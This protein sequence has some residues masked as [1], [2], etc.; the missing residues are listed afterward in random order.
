MY[1]H[2][3]HMTRTNAFKMLL[4]TLLMVVGS[5]FSAHAQLTL[6]TTFVNNARPIIF[7]VGRT[8]ISEADQ[9]WLSDTLRA[10]LEALGDDGI[11]VVRAA[12]SPEGAYKNNLSLA[13]RRCNAAMSVLRQF[14]YDTSELHREIVAE[15]YE[16]LRM[17]M[18]MAG[19]PDYPMLDS[20]VQKYSSTPIVL[21]SK[22]QHVQGGRFWKRVL[23][24]YYPDLRAVRI[25]AVRKELVF[26][27]QFM[28]D[29]QSL[30]IETAQEDTA[31]F[32]PMPKGD[33]P[34]LQ[35]PFQ[36]T[37]RTHRIPLLNV[38][39]N[40]L[41]DAFYMPNYGFAPMWNI[42]VEYYPR[43]G[44]MTYGAWFMGPYWHNWNQNKFFQIRNYELEARY[45]F[46]GTDRAY[47]RGLFVGLAV[48]A[49]KYGIGLN[50]RKG[51][52][53]EGIGGQLV[54]GYAL[55]LDKNKA[56]KLQFTAG[57]GYYYTKYDP[58]I[59]GVPDFFGHEEDGQYYYDTNL[60]RDE[61]KKRQHRFTWLG[62]TQLGVSLSYDLLWR[63]NTNQKQPGGGGKTKGISF[64]PWEK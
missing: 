10:E 33:Y 37:E 55:P 58:Y 44:H 63:R 13:Q 17:E 54:V 16:L 59:Y 62:P 8:V 41:Y 51:W 47:Y 18:K 57:V 3:T 28:P 60:Y 5:I 23:K 15:D 25:M 43:R 53:G 34:V 27:K 40:L 36:Q 6:D 64:R 21:K 32:V 52:Q 11:V 22:M 38:R 19:D 20:L 9:R 35:L 61:F 45:Y 29:L 30:P 42:G 56:W 49:N 12:A 7:E 46:R 2:A 26:G 39:T 4:A 50:K 14:G 1:T 48:D 24:E 31:S